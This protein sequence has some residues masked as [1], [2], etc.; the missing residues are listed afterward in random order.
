MTTDN[1]SQN[2]TANE[3]PGA[4]LDNPS[5]RTFFKRAA[6]GGGAALVAGIGSYAAGKGSVQGQEDPDLQGWYS[7]EY[8]LF[9]PNVA[10]CYSTCIEGDETLVW[11]LLPSEEKTPDVVTEI[12]SE[13][14][15]GIQVEIGSE[16]NKWQLTIPYTNSKNAMVKRFVL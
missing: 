8:N 16:D 13:S 7:P 4:D 10:S 14:E 11:L 3:Q 2:D 6:I 5:R 15:Q 12:I 9:E 1:I